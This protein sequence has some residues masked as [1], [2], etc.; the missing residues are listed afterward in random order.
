MSSGFNKKIDKSVIIAISIVVLMV[1]VITTVFVL[2]P[3]FGMYG[4]YNILAKFNFVEIQFYDRLSKNVVYFG[5]LLF[6]IY[7]VGVFVEILI[8]ISIKMLKLETTKKVLVGSYVVQ[9][10]LSIT[11]FKGIVEKSFSRIDLSWSGTILVFTVIYLFF[12]AISDD[13]KLI[14]KS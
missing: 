11:I 9:L 4:L 3:L 8:K 6:V 5:F 13:H 7:I 2:M 14:K 1:A 10:F 12:Y